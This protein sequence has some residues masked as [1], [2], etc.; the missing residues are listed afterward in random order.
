MRSPEIRSILTGAG[1]IAVL[2]GGFYVFVQDPAINSA[3]L[4]VS[5]S[6]AGNR[7]EC[8]RDMT[9]VIFTPS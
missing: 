7:K 8:G 6:K 9:V 3:L 1:G 5:N 4:I 2:E